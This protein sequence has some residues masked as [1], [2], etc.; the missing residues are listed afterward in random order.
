MQ[1]RRAEDGM[2]STWNGMKVAQAIRPDDRDIVVYLIDSDESRETVFANIVAVK[3]GDIIWRL[4][5][6]GVPDYFVDIDYNG[7]L[8]NAYAFSGQ[9]FQVDPVTGEVINTSFSK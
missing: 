4:H 2:I 7:N 3:G 9:T 5:H 6:P 8:L 1:I